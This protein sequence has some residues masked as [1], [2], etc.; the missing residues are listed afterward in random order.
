MHPFDRRV[1][2][3][4]GI[5]CTWGLGSPRICDSLEVKFDP[6]ALGVGHLDLGWDF[7][8]GTFTQNFTNPSLKVKIFET[9]FT[10][11]TLSVTW[12]PPKTVEIGFDFELGASLLRKTYSVKQLVI[13]DDV[14]RLMQFFRE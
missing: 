14:H 5:S 11:M 6:R 10:E 1:K 9:D 8:S 4:L 3:T 13:P 12:K 2:A 7:A